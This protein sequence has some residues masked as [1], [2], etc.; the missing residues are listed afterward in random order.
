MPVAPRVPAAPGKCAAPLRYPSFRP[1]Q[2]PGRE[3]RPEGSREGPELHCAPAGRAHAGMSTKPRAEIGCAQVLVWQHF[4]DPIQQRKPAPVVGTLIRL[5]LLG[6]HLPP[7]VCELPPLGL[8]GS[9]R[10]LCSC[11]SLGAGLGEAASDLERAGVECLALSRALG[12]R[13]RGRVVA[14]RVEGGV[15]G[16]LGFL[17]SGGRCPGAPSRASPP[18]DSPGHRPV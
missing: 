14:G 16:C 4:G 17:P 13:T 18:R 3:G 7:C 8:P 1:V 11:P 10:I 2:V 12:T 9:L 5:L 15:R 6:F